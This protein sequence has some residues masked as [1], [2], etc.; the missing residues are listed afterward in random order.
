MRNKRIFLKKICA[1][2]ISSMLVLPYFSLGLVCVK[3]EQLDIQ[4]TNNGTGVS[5]AEDE[6]E[7]ISN[8]EKTTDNSNIL[9]NQ[10][11]NKTEQDSTGQV[12]KENDLSEKVGD[13]K[14]QE[15]S[16][17]NITEKKYTFKELKEFAKL[18]KE[19]E[20]E[21]KRQQKEQKSVIENGDYTIEVECFDLSQPDRYSMANVMFA[22]NVDMKVQGAV[23]E[24]KF[25]VPYPIPAFSNLG[26]D[27]TIKNFYIE[28]E[29]KK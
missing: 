26:E 10:K 20:K 1:F 9:E 6:N 4:D 21:E 15:V 11:K 3:A 7:N 5:T 24:L 25:Y 16:N 12:G 29:N 22:K 28:Y 17:E 8:K 27:G 2:M 19:M 13:K 23:T 14:E 18:L